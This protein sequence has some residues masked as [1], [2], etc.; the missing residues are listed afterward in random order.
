[1]VP[2]LLAGSSSQVRVSQV[3]RGT[4]QSVLCVVGGEVRH[5]RLKS[6]AELAKVALKE[7]AAKEAAASGAGSDSLGL[8]DDEEEEDE[9]EEKVSKKHKRSVAAAKKDKDSNNG[10]PLKCNIICQAGIPIRFSVCALEVFL[11][12]SS[13]GFHSFAL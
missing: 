9:T 10:R 1:M 7:Q 11:M 8:S 6:K 12:V 13:A 3:S 2:S 4:T 5:A